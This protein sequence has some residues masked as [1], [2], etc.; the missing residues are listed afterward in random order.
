MTNTKKKKILVVEDEIS[1]LKVYRLKLEKEGF[2]VLFAEDGEEALQKIKEKPDIILLDIILPKRDGFSVLEEIRKKKDFAHVP[3]VV[4]SNLG[5]KEDQ[6]RAHK[7]GAQDYF[8]KANTSM[9][10]IVKII[11]KHLSE[12]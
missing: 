3:I 5:Q 10:D 2:E 1:Y 7:M 12:K 11:K 6:E 9:A 4:A 8:V